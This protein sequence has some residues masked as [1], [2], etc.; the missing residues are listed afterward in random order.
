MPKAQQTFTDD[1]IPSFENPLAVQLLA[2]FGTKV[3]MERLAG[4][5]E[6]SVTSTVQEYIGATPIGSSED[7]VRDAFEEMRTR[8]LVVLVGNDEYMPTPKGM[9]FGSRLSA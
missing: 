1:A 6:I 4:K 9:E 7:E 2:G 3:F 5:T 8:G